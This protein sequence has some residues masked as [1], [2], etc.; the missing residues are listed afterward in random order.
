MNRNKIMKNQKVNR[1]MKK[2]AVLA[3]SA[4][5]AVT[6]FTVSAENVTLLKNDEQTTER[7]KGWLDVSDIVE[8]AMPSVVSIATTSVMEVDNYYGMYGFGFGYMPNTPTEREVKGSGSGIII[9]KSETELLVATNFHVIEDANEVTVTFADG[10][11][12]EASAK[13]Y[14]EDRDLAVVA[15]DLEDIADE[16]MDAIKIAK[17]GSSDDLRVG[18]QVVA[19]GNAL[20]YGQSVT[21]GIVS[22]KNR[23]L[24]GLN[25]DGVDL[26]QTDAA[27]NPGNS[28]GALLNLNGEVVGINS[29]KMASTDVEGMC[30][31]ISIS[32]VTEV[33]ERL[34]NE[35]PR[36]KV[37]GPHGVIGIMGSTVSDEARR[38]GIPQGVHIQ[39]ITKDGA[40]EKAGLKVNFI[41]TKFDGKDINTIDRLVELLEYYAPGEEVEITVK[42]QEAGEYVEKVYTVVLDEQKDTDKKDKDDKKTEEKPG[43]SEKEDGFPKGEEEEDD[44]D[45]DYDYGYDEDYGYDDVFGDLFG[46]LFGDFYGGKGEGRGSDDGYGSFWN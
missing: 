27:I 5:L 8:E 39:E 15:V 6:P 17:I 18:E 34:M 29:A 38:F 45:Y 35:V 37:E 25:D 32:D 19:I 2:G 22:A 46:E 10:E 41:I 33:L 13:G 26:I 24:E 4:L 31:A 3:L 36:T 23:R 21:T 1:L 16:T 44:Y 40:A 30:Y 43:E 28:G 20:G 7:V 42:Y 9:G 14:D 11:S 12:Y